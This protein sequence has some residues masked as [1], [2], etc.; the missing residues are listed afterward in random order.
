[1][2][3]YVESAPSKE[4]RNR[5]KQAAYASAYGSGNSFDH[6]AD[7]MKFWRTENATA[8]AD[9]FYQNFQ[10]PE[11]MDELVARMEAARR[12]YEEAAARR[13]P[14]IQLAGRSRAATTTV[15]LQ[16]QADGTFVDHEA[17]FQ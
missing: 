6:A 1:M 5:R 16:R 12:R 11:Y 10:S 14:M 8:G 15:T 13:R 2:R 9:K 3:E 17:L 4:E 7:A